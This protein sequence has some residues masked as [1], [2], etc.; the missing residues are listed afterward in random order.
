M[1]KLP[2]T[3]RQAQ[4][5]ARLEQ[6]E[7]IKGMIA[8]EPAIHHV[9]RIA[10]AQSKGGDRWFAYSALKTIC[11]DL[12]GWGAYH[13]ELR[14]S[15]HWECMIDAIDELLPNVEEDDGIPPDDYMSELEQAYY[16]AI[17]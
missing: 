9:M 17:A 5:L 15:R 13:P 8:C 16:D 1:H 10:A 11:Y 3:P 12:I 2:A 4:A 14:T 7:Q 6:D